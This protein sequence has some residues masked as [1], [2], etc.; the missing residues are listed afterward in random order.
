VSVRFQLRKQHVWN[1]FYCQ[2][3]HYICPAIYIVKCVSLVEQWDE[4]W[5]PPRKFG[6]DWEEACRGDGFDGKLASLF[7][8][9]TQPSH[10]NC[11]ST[12]LKRVSASHMD[13]TLQYTPDFCMRQIDLLRLFA[14]DLENSRDDRSTVDILN[15]AKNPKTGTLGRMVGLGEFVYSQVATG[16]FLCGLADIPCWRASECP[17]M[18]HKKKHFKTGGSRE[19]DV[20]GKRHKMIHRMKSLETVHRSLLIVAHLE[21]TSEAV[22]ENGGCEGTDRPTEVLDCLLEGMDSFNLRP[23]KNSNPYRCE[24][25][26]WQKAYGAEERWTAIDTSKQH[27]VLRIFVHV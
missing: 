13:K 24:Y 4:L 20:T 11:V 6:R 27:E 23:T 12:F 1:L 16:L 17:I 8:H 10:N 25:K 18:D 3:Q 21:G 14:D 22:I 2:L 7:M 19:D 5:A 15:K 9:M 26:V